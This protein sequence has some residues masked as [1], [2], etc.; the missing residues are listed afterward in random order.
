MDR[1]PVV[2]PMRD[3]DVPFALSLTAT[4]G[5][6]YTAAD[7]AR[8]RT[9]EP[10]GCLVHEYGDQLQGLLTVTTYGEVAWLGAVVVLPEWRGRHV[11]LSM[12]EAA[13]RFCEGRGVRSVRLNAYLHVVPY[14]EKLGFRRETENIRFAVEDR[15]RREG[16]SGGR[17]SIVEDPATLYDLDARYFGTPR[18][19]LLQRLARE[20]E[21]FVIAV[22][23]GGRP[24]GY[25]AASV[26]EAGCEIGP[27]VVEPGEPVAATTLLEEAFGHAAA[28]T[29]AIT[30]PS[31][32]RDAIELLTSMGF[33]EVFR[34]LRMTRGPV[35]PENLSGIWALAGLEKG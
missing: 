23:R 32:N 15:D 20:K 34:T 5:W 26:T 18:R 12:M 30:V 17:A 16:F 2:R 14:Y 8:L 25:L 9:L 13:L 28:A 7:F 33:Q 19:A 4:E 1:P 3:E 29:Y 22:E 35:P 24:I 10:E 11:G 6:G 31:E 27:W 21:A